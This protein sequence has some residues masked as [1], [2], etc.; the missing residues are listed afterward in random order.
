MSGAPPGACPGTTAPTCSAPAARST[1]ARGPPSTRCAAS[2]SAR[3]SR[4]T[5]CGSEESLPLDPA[6]PVR[7]R[8]PLDDEQRGLGIEVRVDD[9]GDVGVE[10]VALR[11]GLDPPG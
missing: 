11:A 2:G 4:R 6:Q 1:S 10:Q 7:G 3:T 5:W 8:P 9:L